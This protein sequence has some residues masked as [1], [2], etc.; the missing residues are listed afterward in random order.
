MNV[1]L[2]SYDDT[3]EHLIV[4]TEGAGDSGT[5]WTVDITTGKA[6]PFGEAYPDSTPKRPWARPRW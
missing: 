1:A 5:Y 4:Y 6:E 3:F 2:K